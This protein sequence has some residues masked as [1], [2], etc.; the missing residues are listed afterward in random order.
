M[1][2]DDSELFH[3]AA[4]LAACLVAAGLYR[5][6]G[7]FGVGLFG[8]LIVF[9]ATSVDLNDWRG[10]G[11]NA[12]LYQQQV[13][14]DERFTRNERAEWKGVRQKR[15]RASDYALMIGLAF[16]VVGGAGFVF[17]QLHLG[18]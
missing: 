7:F 16:L 3:I 1:P 8:M 4:A 13:A 12:G 6:M 17:F 18:Q 5:W 15:R 11:M 2:R 9:L 14:D 10:S